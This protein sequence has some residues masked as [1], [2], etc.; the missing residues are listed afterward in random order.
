MPKKSTR[1]TSPARWEIDK[2]A[3]EHLYA[4]VKLVGS[5]LEFFSNLPEMGTV[6]WL[7]GATRVAAEDENRPAYSMI[8]QI[9]LLGNKCALLP[10]VYVHDLFGRRRG[11]PP[12]PDALRFKALF[13]YLRDP[14]RT[15]WQISKVLYP[16]ERNRKNAYDR[17]RQ[18]IDRSLKALGLPP[19]NEPDS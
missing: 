9:W 13:E 5:H 8:L 4:L 18:Q 11:S 14:T 2:K 1:K 12:S 7:Q 3:E 6:E 15:D 16:N 10:G 17:V 19:R